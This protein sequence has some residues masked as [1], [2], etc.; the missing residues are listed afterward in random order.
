MISLGSLRRK[1]G[2]GLL[3]QR[4]GVLKEEKKT[5]AF[6]SKPRADDYTIKQLIL[7]KDMFSLKRCTNV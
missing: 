4:S 1:R 5:N 2:L 7:L 3:G 6:F